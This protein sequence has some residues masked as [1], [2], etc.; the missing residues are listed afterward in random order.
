LV[1]ENNKEKSEAYNLL[2]FNFEKY[3]T[4][5]SDCQVKD[6]HKVMSEHPFLCSIFLVGKFTTNKEI[7]ELNSNTNINQ[8]NP[9]VSGEYSLAIE[10]EKTKKKLICGTSFFVFFFF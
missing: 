3:T 8:K 6:I 2:K 7:V 5:I 1:L 9:Y 4:I 10:S